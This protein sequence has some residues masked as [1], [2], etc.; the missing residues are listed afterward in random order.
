MATNMPWKSFDHRAPPPSAPFGG[1]LGVIA[2][3]FGIGVLGAYMLD[4]H[5]H[6]CVSCGNRWRHLGAFNMGDQVAHTCG[7]CGTVQWWKCGWEGTFG[8]P[9]GSPVSPRPEFREA[10]RH[11]LPSGTEHLR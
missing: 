11:A 3:A 7:K 6:T 2:I 4:L 9:P 1:T 8:V 10:S 5:G